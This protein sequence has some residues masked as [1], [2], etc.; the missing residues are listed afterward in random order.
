MIQKD[1]KIQWFS[2]EMILKNGVFIFSCIVINF[3]YSMGW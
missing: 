1:E 3:I 2:F